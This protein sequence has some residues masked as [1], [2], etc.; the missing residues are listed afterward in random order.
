VL[1]N[2]TFKIWQSVDVENQAV[3]ERVSLKAYS[4]SG[5]SACEGRK[6][7]FAEFHEQGYELWGCVKSEGFFCQLNRLIK[8]CT[9]EWGPGVA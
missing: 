3:D 4:Y 2:F 9:M 8:T 1:S 7:S 5:R 6:S